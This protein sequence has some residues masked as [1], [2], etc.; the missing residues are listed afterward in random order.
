MSCPFSFVV[1]VADL[2][3]EALPVFLVAAVAL[4]EVFEDAFEVGVA[5]HVAPGWVFAEPGVVFVAEVDGAAEPV[6][7]FG[8]VAFHRK[9]CRQ[10][11][12][13]LAVGFGSGESFV[14]D[15]GSGFFALAELD[16]AE[17]DGGVDDA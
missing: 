15:E 11:I 5:A 14:D 3:Q 13:H 10:A 2:G 8:L 17:G 1:S 9:I 16:V 7:G 12:G 4:F 6:E